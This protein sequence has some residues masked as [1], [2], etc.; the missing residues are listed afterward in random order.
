M[1]E[2]KETYLTETEKEKL[3]I[4]HWPSQAHSWL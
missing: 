1:W 3:T 4:V 2:N